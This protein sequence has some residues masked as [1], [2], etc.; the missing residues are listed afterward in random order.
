MGECIGYGMGCKILFYD[1]FKKM[2]K[3][4]TFLFDLKG[5]NKRYLLYGIFQWLFFLKM[6]ENTAKY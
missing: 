1:A 4:T 2:S 3:V 6:I 5:F